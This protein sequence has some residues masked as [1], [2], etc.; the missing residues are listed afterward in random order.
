MYS[1]DSSSVVEVP[2][3][4]V[5]VLPPGQRDYD[6][7]VPSMK[8]SHTSLPIGESNR[9]TLAEMGTLFIVRSAKDESA[10]WATAL[11]ND[12][13]AFAAV[14]DLHK[15]RIYHHALR[16]TTNVQ[17]AEDVTATAFFE[18]WRRRKSVHLVDDSVLPWLFVTTT[19]LARNST[20]NLRRYRALLD[21]LPRS[22]ESR[23]AEDVAT[24]E[25]AAMETASQIRDILSALSEADATLI[26]LMIFEHYS[27]AQAADALGISVGAARTRLHRART[28]FAAAL[29]AVSAEGEDTHSRED[30]R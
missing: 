7:R 24:E 3:R 9:V 2:K 14:F 26:S 29:D 4:F 19:N 16:M 6:C 23:S 27:T 20:R 28:R 22:M 15:D 13:Q 1:I 17:D 8:T 21:S 18:L 5:S 10:I 12:G 11:E 30:V 25:M